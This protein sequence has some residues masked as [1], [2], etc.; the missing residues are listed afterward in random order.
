MR[1]GKTPQS[2]REP[3]ERFKH[4]IT[5][6]V[7][8]N[9]FDVIAMMKTFGRQRTRLELFDEVFILHVKSPLQE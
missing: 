9:Q 7:K 8:P 3:D 4:R 5:L 2:F 6:Q 1:S